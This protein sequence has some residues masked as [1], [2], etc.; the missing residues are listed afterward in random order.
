MQKFMYTNIRLYADLK[1][2][3]VNTKFFYRDINV[4]ID[5]IILS[6]N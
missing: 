6:M 1:K 2:K 4:F 3:K 5:K